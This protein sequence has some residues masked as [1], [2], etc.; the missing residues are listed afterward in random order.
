MPRTPINRRSSLQDLL[1]LG[2]AGAVIVPT[3]FA[4]TAAPP[5]LPATPP[6]ELLAL[7]APWPQARQ[8]GTTRMRFFGLSIYDA[9]L[10]APP[11]LTITNYSSAPFA[12]E[13]RYLR[14]LSGAAIAQRSLDEMRRG[15]ALATAL[16]TQWLNAMRAAFPDVQSG[17][18]ITGVNRPQQ[19][20]RFYV[21]GQ[22]KAD[23]A[24]SAFAE[25]FFGIWLAP[26]TS[27]PAMRMALIQGLAP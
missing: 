8:L 13:L 23:I 22:L 11:G 12:L 26:W 20:V 17:D 7:P 2:M 10:W 15:G 18:R 16:E 3:A 19:G 21:N 24:D 27:E 25:R 6:P 9:A 1:A 14:N 4:Q 5:A